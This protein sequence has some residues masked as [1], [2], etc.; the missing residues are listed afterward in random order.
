MPS[1]ITHRLGAAEEYV[2]DVVEP[3]LQHAGHHRRLPDAGIRVERAPDLSRERDAVGRGRKRV[4]V[5]AHGEPQQIRLAEAEVASGQVLIRAQE[6]RG[7]D[8]QHE[9]ERHLRDDKRAA[10]A[11]LAASLADA[12]RARATGERRVSARADNPIVSPCPKV[13]AGR[14]Y[15]EFSDV[16]DAVHLDPDL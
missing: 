1:D 15:P 3:G 16:V 7:A 10:R 11:P 4:G 2:G 9:R 8:E 6:Q 14:A 12:R 5:R 13:I